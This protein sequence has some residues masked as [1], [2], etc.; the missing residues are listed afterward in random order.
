M[1]DPAPT[2]SVLI[3][4]YNSAHYLRECI[5]SVLAQTL[6]PVEI[7]ICDDCSTDD[8][9]AI[10]SEY[11]QRYPEIIKAHRQE[12]NI[13]PA[14]NGNFGRKMARGELF[15]KIDG[16]DRWLPR[17]LEM[18]WKAIQRHPDAKIGY[19]DVY[20]IDADGNRTGRWHNHKESDP[21][22][23]DVF[24]EV[25]SRHFFSNTRSIFRDHLI[26]RSLFDEIGYYDEK[27]ESFWD[28]DEKIRF[29]ARY[30]VAYSGE[31][32]VEY[33]QHESAFSK[34]E[35][36]KHFRAMVEIYE[37]HMPLLDQRTATEAIR[38]RC[39]IESFLAL[40]Q[41]HL[42]LSERLSY[43]I[44]SSVH[45]RNVAALARLDKDDRVNLEK[46]LSSTLVQFYLQLM[47]EEIGKRRFGTALTYLPELF[48][49]YRLTNFRFKLSAMFK[50]PRWT[51]NQFRLKLNG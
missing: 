48:H 24:V 50:F 13:G 26:Y 7:I 41:I 14:R 27:L 6:S 5:D 45:E 34:R 21:P 18:E 36:V 44:L 23:G 33:R 49:Y 28:W 40:H 8:S 30:P 9:W 37:K 16:D 3:I 2:I 51:L 47:K 4:A 10:T 1:T 15:A 17:K 11:L 12:E 22:G 19:S 35:P 46:E 31:A 38:I 42:P 39:N 20:I 25:I 43:Y 29:T 32:L